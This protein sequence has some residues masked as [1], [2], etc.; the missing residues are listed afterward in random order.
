ILGALFLVYYSWCI[1]LGTLFLAHYSWHIILGTLFLV[2][3]SW[4]IILGALFLIVL[5]VIFFIIE[6][7]QTLGFFCQLFCTLVYLGRQYLRS[8]NDPSLKT[9]VNKNIPF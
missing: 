9:L 3:Y 2:H 5:I 4:H 6:S 7:L 8:K 1:I